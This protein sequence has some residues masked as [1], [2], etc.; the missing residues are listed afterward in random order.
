M[1]HKKK[2]NSNLRFAFIFCAAVLFLIFASFAVKGIL[3]LKN[4]TFDGEHRF[5]VAILGDNRTSLVSFSPQ[6]RSITILNLKGNTAGEDLG[7]FLELPV[8]ATVRVKDL[9]IDKADISSDIS[10]ILFHYRNTSV[11][12][13]VLDGLRL[14]LFTKDVP[15]SSIYE[16]DLSSKD[17]LSINS[18]TSSFFI[19]TEIANEK[20]T[21]EIING[22]SVYGLGNRLAN[23]LNNIGA[24]VVLVTSSD[25]VEDSTKVLYSGDLSYSVKRIS[26][27][28]GVKPTKTSQRDISDVTIIIGKDITAKF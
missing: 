3:L 16:R 5:N 7:K 10:N 23:L 20:T 17:F 22:T 24:D 9:K 27:I 12:F 26:G 28:L 1:K 4:S 19:D 21:I 25:T 14:L 2:Q 11:N 18:F 15:Q 6:N 8:D 13:T